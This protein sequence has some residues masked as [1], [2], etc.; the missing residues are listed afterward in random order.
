MFGPSVSRVG[1]YIVRSRRY[2]MLA[3]HPS[4]ASGYDAGAETAGFG[5][6]G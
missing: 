4:P 3:G 5:Y 1:A 6:V 2:R